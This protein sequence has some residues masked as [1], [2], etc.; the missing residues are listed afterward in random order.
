FEQV[1]DVAGM[2]AYYQR[3]YRLLGSPAARRA[4]ALEDEPARVRDAYG[5]TRLGQSCLLAR[6][7]VEAGVPFVTVDD[8]GWDHHGNIY[9]ALKSRLPDL[10]RSVAAL[11]ADLDDRG[12]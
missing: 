4:F 12:L 9:P 10:D 2:D 8:D 1:R 11:L 7:L 5:R 3:A 6:R